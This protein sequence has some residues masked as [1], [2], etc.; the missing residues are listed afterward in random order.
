[1]LFEQFLYDYKFSSDREE[2]QTDFGASGETSRKRE[3][4][5]DVVFAVMTVEMLWPKS[6]HG[7]LH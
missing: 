4:S 1:M 6:N 2:G 7:E 5:I 3:F